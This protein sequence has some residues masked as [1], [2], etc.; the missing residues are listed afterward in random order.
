MEECDKEDRSR[1]LCLD[2]KMHVLLSAYRLQGASPALPRSDTQPLLARGALR[3]GTPPYRTTLDNT[4]ILPT[5]DAV[6][7]I[8]R[9]YCHSFYSNHYVNARVDKVIIKD[10]LSEV[11]YQVPRSCDVSRV[12][13]S[14]CVLVCVFVSDCVC[15]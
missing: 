13:P 9:G 15:L 7:Y 14:A 3:A 2:K 1:A 12:S 4:V 10:P 5:A 8:Q 11:G 6:S